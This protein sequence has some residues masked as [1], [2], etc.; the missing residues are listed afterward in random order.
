[1]RAVIINQVLTIRFFPLGVGNQN[2]TVDVKRKGVLPRRRCLGLN[3]RVP[4]D[5]RGTYPIM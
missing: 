3:H 4:A 1:M 2:L 5:F